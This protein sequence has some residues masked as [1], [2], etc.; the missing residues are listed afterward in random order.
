MVVVVLIAVEVIG[1][2]QF[3]HVEVLK[4]V[5]L[6]VEVLPISLVNIGTHL[7][8]EVVSVLD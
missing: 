5:L 3:R 1:K 4:T 6:E 8:V 7:Q 2:R